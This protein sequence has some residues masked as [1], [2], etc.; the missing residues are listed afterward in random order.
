[1]YPVFKGQSHVFMVMP[2]PD[3]TCAVTFPDGDNWGEA[4]GVKR[5]HATADAAFVELFRVAK[6][7]KIKL[8][9]IVEPSRSVA[10]IA[11]EI[12]RNWRNVYFGAVPY[13]DAMGSMDKASDPYGLDS[14]ESILV[15]FLANAN[16]YRGGLAKAHKEELKAL[17][18]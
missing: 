5:A 14:G 16:A 1:M 8:T 17:A 11:R 15:Y 2:L 12:R 6:E 3:G 18:K 4:C 10:S 9:P 13:L 7:R